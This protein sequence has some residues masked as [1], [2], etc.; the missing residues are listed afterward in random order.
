MCL[1]NGYECHDLIF[2]GVKR[3]TFWINLLPWLLRISYVTRSR[4]RRRFHEGREEAEL[5][6]GS[7]YLREVCPSA[8]FAADRS[9]GKVLSKKLGTIVVALTSNRR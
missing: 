1:V 8:G 9:F 6:V 5:R 2:N 4:A 3:S 7:P